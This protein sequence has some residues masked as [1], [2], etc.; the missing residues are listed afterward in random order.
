LTSLAKTVLNM[1]L[2]EIDKHACAIPRVNRPNWNVLQCDMS[3]PG[4]PKGA[5]QR[6]SGQR[7]FSVDQ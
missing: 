2:V 1:R 3:M 4:R 6:C 7:H 5:L